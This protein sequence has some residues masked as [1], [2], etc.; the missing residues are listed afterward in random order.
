MLVLTRR[1]EEGM[2]L[3]IEGLTIHVRLLE[4]QGDQARLGIEAPRRCTILRDELIR[5][6][7]TNQAAAASTLPDLDAVPMPVP[8]EHVR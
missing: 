7:E 3:Q 6:V 8:W 5:V 4:I 1:V 2:T